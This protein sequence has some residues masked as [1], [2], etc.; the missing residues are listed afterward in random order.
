MKFS[1]V[2]TIGVI[3]AIVLFVPPQDLW[4]IIIMLI[5]L[6]IIHIGKR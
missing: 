1:F 3:L 4:R 6:M 2:L 5:I